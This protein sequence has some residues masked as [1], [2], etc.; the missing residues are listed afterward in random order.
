MANSDRMQFWRLLLSVAALHVAG[1]GVLLMGAAEGQFIFGLGGLAYLL[2]LRHAFDVDHI[3]A[4]DNV[5][6]KLSHERRPSMFVGFWF[7]LGHSTVVLGLCIALVLTLGRAEQ[8]MGA[9]ATMGGLLGTTVSA[10]FLTLMASV[11][12]VILARLVSHRAAAS[13]SAAA[14]RHTEQLLAKRGVFARLLAARPARHLDAPWKLYPVG[15]LF[16]LGFDTA[17]EVAV[18]GLSAVA[19]QQGQLAAWVVLAL[20]LL[21]AAGMTLMDSI[22][23]LV[24]RRA[25][26]WGEAGGSRR[27][28]FNI[29]MTGLSVALALAIAGLQWLSLATDLYAPDSRTADWLANQHFEYWGGAVLAAFVACWGVALVIQQ[30]TTIHV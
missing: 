16:G 8:G 19:I 21:F 24:M 14:A 2:G 4:I 3:T 29:L 13:Q 11:N 7:S 9:I 15:L 1:T 10:A 28:G 18:L 30:R 17:T 25:Y 23:G 20:P 6:R 12:I 5:T 22:N 27:L 26:R